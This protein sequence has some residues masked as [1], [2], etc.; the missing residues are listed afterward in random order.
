LASSIE[1]FAIQVRHWQRTEVYEAEEFFA[2][3][4]K[5]SSAMPH[6]RNPIL[7]ENITGLARIIR[8]YSIPAHGKCCPM[9]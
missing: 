9:A 5:G 3:G 4:Q 2:K 7:T 1:K 6:K 8:A